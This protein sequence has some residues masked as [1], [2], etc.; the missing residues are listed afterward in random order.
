MALDKKQQIEKLWQK[1]IDFSN[2]LIEHRPQ[3]SIGQRWYL[4]KNDT[5]YKL[6]IDEQINN[7]NHDN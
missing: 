3:M 7:V 5:S 4:Y 6:V 1:E 2:S